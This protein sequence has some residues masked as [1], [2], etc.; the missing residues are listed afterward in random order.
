MKQQIHIKIDID[1]DGSKF[2]TSRYISNTPHDLVDSFIER[3]LKISCKELV[4]YVAH[5]FTGQ[6]LNILGKTTTINYF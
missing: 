3:E 2:G 6:M 5:R 1:I 4:N